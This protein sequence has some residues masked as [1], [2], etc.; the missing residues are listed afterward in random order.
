MMN[1][2]FNGLVCAVCIM[3]CGFYS[4]S[5][6]SATAGTAVFKTMNITGKSRTSSGIKVDYAVKTQ[7]DHPSIPK[8]KNVSAGFM[9]ADLAAL[10]ASLKNRNPGAAA[11]GAATVG[12]AAAA[13]WVIDELTGQITKPVQ[14]EVVNGQYGYY[15]VGTTHPIS[16]GPIVPTFTDAFNS[17]PGIVPYKDFNLV[18]H[19]FVDYGITSTSSDKQAGYIIYNHQNPDGTPNSGSSQLSIMIINCS[20]FKYAMESY[21]S[22]V[23][24]T[25]TVTEFE[26]VPDQEFND[27]VADW[28]KNAPWSVLDD[29]LKHPDG[30]PVDA[31]PVRRAIGDW[32]DDLAS[33]DPNLRFE[34]PASIV[35]TNPDGSETPVEFEPTPEPD[36]STEEKTRPDAADWPLFCEWAPVICD[37]LDWTKEMPE[38][39]EPDELPVDE[40]TI[41]DLKKDYTPGLGGGSCPAPVTFQ[42][43]G[44]SMQFKYDDACW[45]ASNV[46][47]PVLLTMA[48]IMAAFIIVGASRR[49]V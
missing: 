31:E 19:S 29:L 4:V 36:P 23:G 26:P 35:V 2:R 18:K 16:P 13:G 7:F 39:M 42:Y 1:G 34:P 38:E 6:N 25:T 10:F 49:A 27:K 48:G 43:A 46:F 8:N 24:E 28:L 45:A 17:A 33:R 37:W 20:Y 32:L 5:V 11:V 30:T 15:H 40:I 9:A 22:Q 44:Q 12:A 47:R 21:C 41:A 14:K 3:F